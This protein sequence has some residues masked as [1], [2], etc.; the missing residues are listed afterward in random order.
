MLEPDVKLREM[1][2]KAQ[3]QFDT[4]CADILDGQGSLT[5]LLVKAYRYGHPK[6]KAEECFTVL[7]HMLEDARD[8][9]NAAIAQPEPKISSKSRIV[10]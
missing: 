7:F 5:A 4:I 9:Y 6:E 1:K 10:L 2:G 8:T 3:A